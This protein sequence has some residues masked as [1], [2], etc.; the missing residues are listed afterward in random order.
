MRLSSAVLVTAALL[1]A[2]SAFAADP[3]TPR[4]LLPL[5][6]S[7]FAFGSSAVDEATSSA[8]SSIGLAPDEL[9]VQADCLVWEARVAPKAELLQPFPLRPAVPPGFPHQSP[10]SPALALPT[11]PRVTVSRVPVGPPSPNPFNP[12]EASSSFRLGLT[13]PPSP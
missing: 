8:P 9:S 12:A 3:C 10:Q 1:R 4:P 2:Y 13:L 11:L 7:A 5:H 6:A